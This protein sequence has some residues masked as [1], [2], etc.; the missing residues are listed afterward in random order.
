MTA[1]AGVGTGPSAAVAGGSWDCCA[2]LVTLQGPDVAAAAGAVSGGGLVGAKPEKMEVQAHPDWAEG[3]EVAAE[4]LVPLLHLHHSLAGQLWHSAAASGDGVGAGASAGGQLRP[5]A[6]PPILDN[7]APVGLG[8]HQ[9]VEGQEVVLQGPV[10]LKE[11]ASQAVPCSPALVVAVAA[12]TDHDLLP[13]AAAVVD[14]AAA[15]GDAVS[16]AAL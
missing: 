8:D 12:G 1:P 2:G 14:A 16:L 6:G 10:P 7:L 13:F 11:A 4:D 5:A 15:A 3:P 9:A